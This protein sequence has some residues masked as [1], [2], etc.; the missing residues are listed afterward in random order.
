MARPCPQLL[1]QLPAECVT[2]RLMFV[3]VGI[4]YAGPV[5]MY[6][7]FGS[8]RQPVVSKSYICIFV[9]LSIKAVQLELVLDLTSEVFIATLRRFLP[10]EVIHF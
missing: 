6:T 8:K 2:P 10:E 1:R 5:Y 9:S 4:D 3:K 7:K